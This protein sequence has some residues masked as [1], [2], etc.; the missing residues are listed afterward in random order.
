MLRIKSMLAL[1]FCIPTLCA[2]VSAGTYYVSPL[3][4]NGNAGTSED[5]PFQMVQHAVDKM[6]AGDT[7]VVLDG[8][9]TGTLKL[10]SGIN[11]RA[12][13]PRKVV[14]SGAERLTGTFEQHSENIYKIQVDKDIERV[15]YQNEPM[16]WAQWPNISWAE[17]WQADKKWVSSSKGSGPG[18]LAC[19]DFR[20]L[21]GRD[22][23]GGYVFLRY[24]KGNSCYSRQIKSFDGRTIHW[25]DTDFYSVPFSGEDGRR[26]SPAAIAKGKSK[27]EV[28]ARFFLAGSLDLLDSE[29]E[30]FAEDGT[31]YLYVTG[32]VKPEASDVLCKTNDYA[33]YETEP[34]SDLIIEGVDFFATSVKFQSPQNKNIQ[35]RDDH[36]TYIGGSL[37]FKD[38][39]TGVKN[40]KPI[41]IEG[42]KIRFENCLFAGAQNTALTLGGSLNVVENCVF[43]ENNRNANFQSTGLIL[44]PKAAFKVSHNTFFNNCSDAIR[45]KMSDNYDDSVK[46]QISYNNICNAGIFNSDVSGVYMPNLSQYW[47]EFHH[48]W[49]HNIHG[50]GVRLDQAG[51]KL[52]VHHNVFWASKRGLNIEGYGNF[53]VY[54]NTSVLNKE[55]GGMTR[56]VVSKRKGTG[57]AVV[58]NDTSFSPITDWNILNNLVTNLVDR[59]GPSE[60]GPFSESLASGKLHPERPKK[61][62]LPI[63]D[64]GDVQGNLT[65]FKQSIFTN[66]NLKNLNLIPKSKIIEGGATPT[67]K[68]ESE[69][70]TELGT[71][72]GAY[73]LNDKGW[74]VGS[75]WMPYGIAVPQTMAQSEQFAKKFRNVSIVPRINLTSLPT[76]RLSQKSFVK[77]SDVALSKEE[78]R[79]KKRMERRNAK[80]MKAN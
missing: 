28:R 51:E 72:R 44:R 60:K 45:F 52:T 3:G 1:A 61:G 22:L 19:D 5:Q 57:D 27:S 67:K 53:N 6:K 14:F 58:S 43:A 29:G 32:G 37:L 38:T 59:V 12:K 50:N 31:L 8:V 7:L 64:R 80:S 36:F 23:V 69:G 17:N 26:G 48:N 21:K 4:D 47:T 74:A 55:A 76:G 24:S 41:D 71:Y 63:T 2:T 35:F 73:D 46:P 18:V 11:I 42:S 77:P 34:V 39:P 75:D 20:S 65:G 49:V 79:K 66:G 25:D 10:K 78:M 54:N 56:N 30:W 62:N 33:I 16:T 15:F 70:V 9:Y 13:N 68:L 40:S